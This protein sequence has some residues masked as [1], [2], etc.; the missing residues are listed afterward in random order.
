M[1]RAGP[2]PN[3]RHKLMNN[4]PCAIITLFCYYIIDYETIVSILCPPD[5]YSQRYTTIRKLLLIS[6]YDDADDALI[7]R[8][9]IH[10][11]YRCY[12]YNI[13]HDRL[14]VHDT[15][16]LQVWC[17]LAEY[18]LSIGQ[19]PLG[20]PSAVGGNCAMVRVLCLCCR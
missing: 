19:K 2:R 6:A 7:C 16:S 10:I 20:V 12:G 5:D 18:S 1:T 8:Q 9:G 4:H 13:T 14:W 17:Q 11:L 15:S 3:I